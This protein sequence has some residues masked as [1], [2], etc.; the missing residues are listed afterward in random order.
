MSAPVAADVPACPDGAPSGAAGV[1]LAG[2]YVAVRTDARWDRR[3]L[4]L[5]PFSSRA[6]ACEHLPRVRDHVNAQSRGGG[7]WSFDTVRVSARPGRRLPD[8]TLNAL[9][10]VTPPPSPGPSGGRG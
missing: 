10:T 7:W 8:G 2:F 5:G 1:G 4:A 6:A 9:L 3:A